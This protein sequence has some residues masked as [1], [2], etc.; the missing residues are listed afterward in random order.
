LGLPQLVAI[1]IG[2]VIGVGIFFTPSQVAKMAGSESRALLLWAI[3]GVVAAT[4]GVVFGELG[5]RSPRVG[6]QYHAVRSAWGPFAGF[7][8]VVCLLTAIQAGSAAIIA[9]IAARNLGV[10][11]GIEL[12]ETAV[13]ILALGMIASVMATNA[14]GVRQ[15]AGVQVLTVAVKLTALAA[16]VGLAVTWAPAGAA[17]P[18]SAATP[19]VGIGFLAGL[20]P[21]LFSFGGWQHALWMAGE[22]R[23]PERNLPR[24]IALGVAVVVVAY[25]AAAWAYFALLG[26][27]GVVGAK[28]LAAEAVATVLPGGARVVAGAVAISAFGVLNAQ[29]LAGPRQFWALARDGLFFRSIGWLHPTRQTPVAAIVALGACA[30]TVLLAAGA[31]GLGPLTAWTVVVDALFFALTALALLKAHYAER[32]FG[33]ITLA[34]CVFVALEVGAM[35]GALATPGVR[36]AALTGLSWVAGVALLYGVGFRARREGR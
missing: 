10:A 32:R 5:R 6:G 33:W 9:L 30:S 7:V 28:A 15:G 21:A 22:V 24:G 12:G 29:F 3:G 17:A 26:F 31:Q 19:A 25:V 18:A 16:I 14:W 35:L 11:L 4:G 23:D 27:D 8:Y 1:V 34:G 13:E 20:L 36:G 2:A